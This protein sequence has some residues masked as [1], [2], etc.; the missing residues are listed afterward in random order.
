MPLYWQIAAISWTATSERAGAPG[1]RPADLK[2]ALP[3]AGIL[4]RSLKYMGALAEPWPDMAF[5]QAV[6]AQ[7]LKAPACYRYA[8]APRPATLN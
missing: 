2:R 5:V 4:A 7:S 8:G 3:T 6:L 1:D